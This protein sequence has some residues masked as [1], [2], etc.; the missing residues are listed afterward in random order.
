MKGSGRG[1]STTINAACRS[2]TTLTK[3]RICAAVGAYA[4]YRV[5]MEAV[6]ARC[7]LR[8]S[9]TPDNEKLLIQYIHGGW[10]IDAEQEVVSVQ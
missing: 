5:P 7:R 6:I 1:H 8:H 4:A 9:G 3:L 10:S 2:R